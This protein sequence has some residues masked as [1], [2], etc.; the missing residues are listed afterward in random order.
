[1]WK[2]EN[3][4]Y[5]YVITV[6]ENGESMWI[7]IVSLNL[8]KFVLSIYKNTSKVNAPTQYLTTLPGQKY[9]NNNN[10]FTVMVPSSIIT[11]VDGFT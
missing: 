5:K 1:M 11:V 10:Y 7:A 6:E 8:I 3:S 9:L 4:I 2:Q